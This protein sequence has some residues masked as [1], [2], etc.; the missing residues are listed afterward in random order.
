MAS[1]AITDIEDVAASPVQVE[2]GV[3]SGHAIESC[4]RCASTLR[5]APERLLREIT[6]LS[7]CPLQ[8]GDDRSRLCAKLVENAIYRPGVK[9]LVTRD[10][11]LFKHHVST[12]LPN[13]LGV[14]LATVSVSFGKMPPLLAPQG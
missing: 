5:D 8:D 13:E 7:L 2:L 9:H 14:T 1:G 6:V 11:G 10:S 3:K 4:E 12:S